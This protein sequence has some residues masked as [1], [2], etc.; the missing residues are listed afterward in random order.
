MFWSIVVV[1]GWLE[2][3]VVLGTEAL[4]ELGLGLGLGFLELVFRWFC[5]GL[6]SGVES[7]RHFQLIIGD[8]MM[9][10]DGEGMAVV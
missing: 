1:S 9:I 5:V 2:T 7:A 6:G 4:V 10:G 8:F 3:M